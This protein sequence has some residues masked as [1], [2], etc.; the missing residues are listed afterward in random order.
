MTDRFN[1]AF[2]SM[3]EERLEVPESYS[4]GEVISQILDFETDPDV[5]ENLLSST[6]IL[7]LSGDGADL[8]EDYID[9]IENQK[10]FAQ[11]LDST[12][13]SPHKKNQYRMSLSE[14]EDLSSKFERAVNEEKRLER[15]ARKLEDSHLMSEVG[16]EKNQIEKAGKKLSA[17]L[18]KKENLEEL[19]EEYRRL[20]NSVESFQVVNSLEQRKA[21]LQIVQNNYTEA[22]KRDSGKL[23]VFL[24]RKFRDSLVNNASRYNEEIAGFF[25]CR[26]EGRDCTVLRIVKTGVGDEQ[27][28]NPNS[29]KYDALNE[30]LNKHKKYE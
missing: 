10:E 28:V 9:E 26:K 29:K 2:K 25:I 21:V 5:V 14:A 3:L 15:V 22:S 4:K 20:E 24:P 1:G 6:C 23:K 30:L 7:Y 12:Q 13:T 16:F 17:L 11:K 19:L 18:E 8:I 27:S